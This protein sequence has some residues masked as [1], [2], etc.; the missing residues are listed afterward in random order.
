MAIVHSNAMV[1]DWLADNMVS[2]E[3]APRDTAERIVNYLTDFS[4]MSSHAHHLMRDRCRTIGLKIEDLEEDQQLQELVLSVHHSYVVTFARNK[5]VKI[6]D[7]SIGS[8][9]NISEN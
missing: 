7:N 1:T 9:W 5:S 8:S 6:I 2:D 3:A 4:S